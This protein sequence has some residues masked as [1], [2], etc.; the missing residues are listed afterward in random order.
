M[1]RATKK[2]TKKA[3]KASPAKGRKKA[4]PERSSAGKPR[5]RKGKAPAAGGPRASE[6]K[7]ATIVE[8]ADAREARKKRADD[9]IEKHVVYSMLSG[10]IPIPLVDL[11]AGTA[12]QLDMLKQLARN[13]GVTFDARSSRAFLTSIGAALAAGAAGRL[14]ASAAKTLP[15]VGSI[16]GGLAQATLTGATTYA[17]G[18]LAGRLFRERR[19]LETFAV[20][21]VRDEL[22]RYYEKG[23]EL[24]QSVV[25]KVRGK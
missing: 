17:I 8:L 4:R 23:K 16:A 12:V 18:E 6:P 2:V 20:D 9:I 21:D 11:A 14:A 19:P 3:R 22:G 25:D 1:K 13:Y 7:P 5:A 15:G 10:A 24:A